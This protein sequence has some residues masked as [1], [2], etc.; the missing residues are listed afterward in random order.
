MSTIFLPNRA[1]NIKNKKVFIIKVQAVTSTEMMKKSHNKKV[2]QTNLKL[3]V[4]K[5]PNCFRLFRS[6]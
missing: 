5:I 2:I 3:N 1:A 4:I 6:Y